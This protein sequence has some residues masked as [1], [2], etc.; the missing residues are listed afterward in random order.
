MLEEDELTQLVASAQAG[1]R[2]SLDRLLVR[3]RPTVMRRCSRFL[4]H[5]A[6]AEEAAQDALLS[7]ST[8]LHEYT[9]RGSFLGWV[10]VIA[11]NAARST[12]RSMRRR[13][14]DSH[15]IVPDGVDPRTTSVIAG[16][17]LDLM[18]S[19]AALEERHPALV[20]SFVLRDLGDLTYLQVAEIT[21][22]PLGTVK[23]RIH[24]ARRF[25]R[26][27]LGGGL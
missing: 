16:T 3:L 27:R 13:A 5:H 20:E 8:H 9:G 18:E 1:D 2:A 6:D 26:D 23:D 4:P 25:M 10:T 19:L 15:A 12:Y 11:S 17:R 21:G 22:A 14:E 24:Q 7:I